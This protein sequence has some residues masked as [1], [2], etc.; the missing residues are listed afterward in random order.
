MEYTIKIVILSFLLF[1]VTSSAHATLYTFAD[2]PDDYHGTT[3][4]P[5]ASATMDIQVNDN[6][7]A[8]DLWNTSP[9]KLTNSTGDFINTPGITGFGF[10][11]QNNQI[12]VIED[13]SLH[14]YNSTESKVLIGGTSFNGNTD[15]EWTLT[16]DNYDG[17]RV[18]FISNT[19]DV[20]GALYN[21]EAKDGFG[22]QPN[23]FTLAELSLE[24]D[25]QPTLDFTSENSPFVRMKNVGPDGEYSTKSGGTPVPEP[26]SMLLLGSGLLGISA[27]CR[28]KF[29]K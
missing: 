1:L 7:L 19:T 27:F 14:A 2:N 3:N 10:D 8:V 9:T 15:G 17:I 6:D 26:A 28:K 16:D 18:D 22:A 13:W 11:F 4:A 24:F 23:Y 25:S 29:K 20:K 21:P 5:M 12:P